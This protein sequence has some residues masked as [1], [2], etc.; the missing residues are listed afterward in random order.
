MND[1]QTLRSLKPHGTVG[2]N[3]PE[4]CRTALI[5]AIDSERRASVQPRASRPARSRRIL[6]AAAA[7]VVVIASVPLVA[8]QRN[9]SAPGSNTSAVEFALVA[10]RVERTPAA[11]DLGP[12]QFLAERSKVFMAESL[13]PE[14]AGGRS[15]PDTPPWIQTEEVEARSW[16]TSR[17]ELVSELTPETIPVEFPTAQDRKNWIAAGRPNMVVGVTIPGASSSD[18]DRPFALGNETVSYSQL[19]D[20][21]QNQSELREVIEKL[22]FTEMAEPARTMYIVENLLNY[23]I[24]TQTRSTL[25]RMLAD[26]PGIRHRSDLTDSLGRPAGGIEWNDGAYRNELLYDPATGLDL[27]HRQFV[28]DPTAAPQPN[29][30]RN[31]MITLRRTIVSRGVVDAKGDLP[32]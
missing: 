16:M 1:S 17:G 30:Y 26:T 20:L 11:F 25:F 21:P 23:P 12:G 7:C 18:K 31:G 9:G 3:T 29:A 14:V 4:A 15:Q 24:S 22:S 13:G 5:E 2:Q 32:R 19:R 6:L 8:G 27:E 10:D 28:V